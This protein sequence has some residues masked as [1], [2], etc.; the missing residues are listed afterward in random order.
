M[1]GNEF[2]QGKRARAGRR[3]R[4]RFLNLDL[5]AQ[6]HARNIFA[7]RN[8]QSLEQQEGLL[9]IL[10]DRLLLGV[11]PK[12]DHRAQGIERC[13]VLLPVMVERLE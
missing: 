8:Q 3:Q 5:G 6:Q 12:V 13:E 1:M 2:R 11:A 10:V 7:D 9:L 4:S